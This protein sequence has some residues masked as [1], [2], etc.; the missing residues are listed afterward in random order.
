MPGPE[1]IT[2]KEF[3]DAVKNIQ[4]WYSK[5]ALNRNGELY[6][7]EYFCGMNDTLERLQTALGYYQQVP[8][9]DRDY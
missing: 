9:K 2:R 4:K 1:I 3:F 5:T 8:I 6:S 7:D